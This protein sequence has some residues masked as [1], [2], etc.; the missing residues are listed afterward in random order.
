MPDPMTVDDLKEEL[1][2]S[3]RRAWTREVEDLKP[4]SDITSEEIARWTAK[5]AEK[6]DLAI[7]ALV[8]EE[9]AQVEK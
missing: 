2:N 1:R 8:A 3:F 9:V 4:E 7:K 6:M 5:A